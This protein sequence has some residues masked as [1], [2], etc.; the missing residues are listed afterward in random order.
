MRI[1]IDFFFGLSLRIESSE[2]ENSMKTKS[3]RYVVILAGGSG[4]RLWPLSRTHKP[5]QLLPFYGTTTLLEKTIERMSSYAPSEQQFIVTT[6]TYAADIKE[7]VA[8]T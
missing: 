1:L 5:K 8:D 6:Q 4:T 3:N 7:L 2:S